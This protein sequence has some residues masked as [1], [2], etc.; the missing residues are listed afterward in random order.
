MNYFIKRGDKEYGPYSLAVLQQYVSQGNI[1]LQDLARSEAMTDW[2]PVSS[3]LGNV[4]VPVASGFGT[5]PSGP[6][7]HLNPPPSLHWAIVVVLGIVTFGIFWIIWIFIQAGWIRK[8]VPESRAIFFLLGYFVAIIAGIG[9]GNNPVGLLLRLGGFVVY[10]IGIFKMRSDIEDYYA[11]LNPSGLSL[12]G[13]MTFFF[14]T[15]YFQYHM[16]EI[17]EA[18]N[19]R[20]SAMAAAQ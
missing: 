9:F 19:Y 3:V 15:A 14:N 10:I 11:T 8:V 12:S 2:V 5:V 17:R 7:P 20:G 16:P 4:P 6:A 1:S 13:V 18:Q